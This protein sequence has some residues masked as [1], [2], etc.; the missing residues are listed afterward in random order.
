[1][2]S[3]N[4]GRTAAGLSG[5]SCE[6]NLIRKGFAEMTGL[7][8]HVGFAS[9]VTDKKFSKRRAGIELLAT[10]ALA[11]SLAV[12]ATA[13]S[14]GVA[15]AQALGAVT[16]HDGT[17]MAIGLCLAA[18]MIGTAGLTAVVS[19]GTRHRRG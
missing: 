3:P 9:P 5:D 12:A 1:M 4:F 14:I 10:I 11:V 18:V 15:R 16:R 6:C 2:G 13:V 8:G 7:T 19:R 17:A